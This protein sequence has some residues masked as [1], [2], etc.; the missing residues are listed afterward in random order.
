MDQ[1]SL[2]ALAKSASNPLA[3]VLA[4]NRLKTEG[5]KFYPVILGRDETAGGGEV[6]ELEDLGLSVLMKLF[7]RC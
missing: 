2:S 6:G 7:T 4:A 5:P 3:S 1:L